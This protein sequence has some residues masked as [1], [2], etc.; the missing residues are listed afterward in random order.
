MEKD[1]S[2]RVQFP[3]KAMEA[4]KPK[5]RNKAKATKVSNQATLKSTIGKR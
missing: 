5:A 3:L 2:Q 1:P 4:L